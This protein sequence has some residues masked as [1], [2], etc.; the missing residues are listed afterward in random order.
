MIAEIATAA[1]LSGAAIGYMIG[2]AGK[3]AIQASRDHWILKA[4]D[5]HLKWIAAERQLISIKRQRSD[6]T[7]RGNITKRLKREAAKVSA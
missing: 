3:A 2:K 6:N 1:A 7:R 5:S 4:D